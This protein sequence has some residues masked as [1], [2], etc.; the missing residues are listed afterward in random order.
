M[1]FKSEAGLCLKYRVERRLLIRCQEFINS[2]VK[3]IEGKDLS[4]V[5]RV[6]CFLRVH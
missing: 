5:Y 4:A 1:G 2:M 6:V 3:S